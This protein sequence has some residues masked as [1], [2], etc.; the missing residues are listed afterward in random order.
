MTFD[1][2]ATQ[3]QHQATLGDFIRIELEL[4]STLMNTALMAESAGHLDHYA[5]A[6]IA[7]AKAAEAVR[8]FIERVQD[9]RERATISRQLEEL[10]DLISRL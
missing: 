9:P 10:D 2:Q 7:A 8:H 6:K 1:F 3:S 4:C 5:R